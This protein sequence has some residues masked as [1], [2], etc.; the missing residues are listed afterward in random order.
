MAPFVSL[1]VYSKSLRTK[2]SLNVQQWHWKLQESWNY[3]FDW[4]TGFFVFVNV[5]FT[6]LNEP[7]RDFNKG[8]E[9]LKMVW[10]EWFHSKYSK[11]EQSDE[12]TKAMMKSLYVH[13]TL[14]FI[15]IDCIVCYV[16]QNLPYQGEFQVNGNNTFCL[17]FLRSSFFLIHMKREM[18]LKNATITKNAAWDCG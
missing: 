15:L 7:Q 2:K 4:L 10:R 17:I 14:F 5:L 12:G 3:M 13:Y 9:R 16:W 8:C 18:L 6:Q 11:W 1:F